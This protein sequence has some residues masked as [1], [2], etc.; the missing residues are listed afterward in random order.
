VDQDIDTFLHHRVGK[1]SDL[2]PI[3]DLK[4]ME[5]DVAR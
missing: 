2:R 5:H 1:G 4:R 3:T